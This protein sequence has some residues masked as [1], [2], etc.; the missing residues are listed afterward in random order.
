MAA[1]LSE[2]SELH[3]RVGDE[4]GHSHPHH[5]ARQVE[6]RW[7][8]VP[9]EEPPGCLVDD[10]IQPGTRDQGQCSYGKYEATRSDGKCQCDSEAHGKA[11]EW[12][13]HGSGHESSTGREEEQLPPRGAPSGGGERRCEGRLHRCRIDVGYGYGAGGGLLGS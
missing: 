6:L 7:P 10:D 1:G 3:H 8:E 5:R 11:G 9:R 12:R 13:R 4:E 2:T